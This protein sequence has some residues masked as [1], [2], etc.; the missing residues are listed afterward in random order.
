MTAPTAPAWLFEHV[1]RLPD[2][3]RG[4]A[5]GFMA[6]GFVAGVEAG[7]RAAGDAIRP[8]MTRLAGMEPIVRRIVSEHQGEQAAPA[9][10]L[11]LAREALGLDYFTGTQP[12]EEPEL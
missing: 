5:L 3:Q 4:T 6:S 9:S 12:D 11:A 8:Q 2:E 1:E 7:R 10:L